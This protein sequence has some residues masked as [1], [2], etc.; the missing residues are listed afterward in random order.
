M[1]AIAEYE[2]GEHFVQQEDLESAQEHL[3]AAQTLCNRTANCGDSW[4]PRSIQQAIAFYARLRPIARRGAM[5]CSVSTL[6]RCVSD[7]QEGDSDQSEAEDESRDA[8]KQEEEEEEPQRP[9]ERRQAF[10]LKKT[11]PQP[12]SLMSTLMSTTG[13]NSLSGPKP[14]RTMAWRESV[15]TTAW[16]AG[17]QV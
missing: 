10:Y 9:K 8:W 2:M 12:R 7:E 6:L 3:R 13:G 5:R 11:S 17:S 16:P 15:F 4:R 1:E 14:K